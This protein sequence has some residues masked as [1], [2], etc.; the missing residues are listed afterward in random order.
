MCVHCAL[1]VGCHRLQKMKTYSTQVEDFASNFKRVNGWNKRPEKQ[2]AASELRSV[3][4]KL[5]SQKA[6]SDE[7][8]LKISKAEEKHGKDSTEFIE[9]Q[10]ALMTYMTA[11]IGK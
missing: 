4:S 9:A 3:N 10:A 1:G 11:N 6:A 8:M 7:L 2:A 5:L